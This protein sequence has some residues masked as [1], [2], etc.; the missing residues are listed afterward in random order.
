MAILSKTNNIHLALEAPEE[1]D[2]EHGAVEDVPDLALVV[3]VHQVVVVPVVPADV[4]LPLL[5][6]L[7][8]RLVVRREQVLVVLEPLQRLLGHRPRD[9]SVYEFMADQLLM[10][11]YDKLQFQ[12]PYSEKQI[13]MGNVRDRMD[14][15]QNFYENEEP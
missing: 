5:L 12:G 6:R 1:E 3:V 2:S 7:A 15:A 10:I 14:N 4:R 9:T 11:D 13:C 8:A